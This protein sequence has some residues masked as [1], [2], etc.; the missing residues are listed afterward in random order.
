MLYLSS[1]QLSGALDPAFASWTQLSVLYLSS[2]QLSGTLDRAFASWTQLSGLDLFSTQL[3]GTVDPAFASWT[4]LSALGLFSTQLSGTLDP[5]FVRWTQLSVLSLSSTRLS[6]A[7]D[8]AFASWTQLSEL[9]MSRSRLQGSLGSWLSAWQHLRRLSIACTNISRVSKELYAIPGVQSLDLS[10]SSI[11]YSPDDCPD[12]VRA[13]KLDLSGN[14]WGGVSLPD[15]LSCLVKPNSSLSEL[16]LRGMGLT[17][18]L[19]ADAGHESVSRLRIDG[20]PVTC[21]PRYGSYGLSTVLVE[22]SVRETHL[23]SCYSLDLSPV[24]VVDASFTNVTYCYDGATMSNPTLSALSVRGV[25]PSLTCNRTNERAA[26]NSTFPKCAEHASGCQAIAT[27]NS[28]ASAGLNSTLC[29]LPNKVVFAG[30]N[31]TCPSWS[32]AQ[33]GGAARLDVDAAFLSFWGCVCPPGHFWGRASLEELDGENLSP[34]LSMG[35]RERALELRSCRPCP[36]DL[37]LSCSPLAPT[38]PPHVVNMSVYPFQP[39]GG[40]PLRSR[41]PYLSRGELVACLHPAVCGG[42]SALVDV[43]DNWTPSG[44]FND[45]APELGDAFMCREGHDPLSPL[46]ATCV[47]G[48]WLDGFLCQRCFRGAEALVVLGLLLGLVLLAYVV[49][50]HHRAAVGTHDNYASIALWYFQVSQALQLSAQINA[51]QRGDAHSADSSGLSALLPV[52]SFRPWALECLARAWDYRASSVLLLALPWA[53]AA[54]GL[55]L[56]SWRR[57]SIFALDLL[58]LPVAQRAVQW[59]NQRA[60][61]HGHVS[62][63]QATCCVCPTLT[64]AWARSAACSCTRPR[65]AMR[66]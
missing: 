59:F 66:A 54:L 15:A 47:P 53:V 30:T 39:G 24:S 4:Q 11:A 43:W 35:Q 18:P 48:Y 6:G 37:P 8:P 22:L 38:N 12:V 29:Q 14:A 58:F 27:R 41:L 50:R 42:P 16:S 21:D 19:L 10:N 45:E 20:N 13:A 46:C 28:I 34:D 36:S 5:A 52:L 9:D 60:L 31:L 26:L 7:L 44:P 64:R 32:T 62:A 49:W 51:A 40:A 65:R 25:R 17:G 33:S 57:A 23:S 2:T 63:P 1:T 55:A 3:S 61:P 56:P